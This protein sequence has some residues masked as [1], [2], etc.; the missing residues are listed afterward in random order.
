MIQISLYI[1]TT[2][3]RPDT[4]PT[5][6]RKSSQI[7]K[8]KKAAKAIPSLD[9]YVRLDNYIPLPFQNTAKLILDYLRKLSEIKFD[10]Y[11]KISDKTFLT[12]LS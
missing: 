7:C 2:T 6:E 1:Y 12:H 8:D 4:H 5:Q 9:N 11:L 3:R 10:N